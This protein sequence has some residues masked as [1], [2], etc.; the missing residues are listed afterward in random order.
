MGEEDVS[1]PKP[2]PDGLRIVAECTKSQNLA[3][4][5]DSVDDARSARASNVSF[6]GVADRNQTS[7][8][9]AL[10]A[11]G[12]TAIVENVNELEE[13]LYAKR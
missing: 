2:A 10:C 4:V 11:E 8:A 7:L 3:Y 9:E 1:H 5:G 12:A 6:I 13:V